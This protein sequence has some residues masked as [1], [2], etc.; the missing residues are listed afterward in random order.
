MDVTAMK[1]SAMS[2]ADV[3]I[4]RMMSEAL[5]RRCGAL[6]LGRA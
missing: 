5:V 3:I 2:K 1:M 4:V 6:A